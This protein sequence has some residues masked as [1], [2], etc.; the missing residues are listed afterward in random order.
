MGPSGSASIE[1]MPAQTVD[2]RLASD[3]HHQARGQPD[4]NDTP[5]KSR[6][7]TGISWFIAMFAII[8]STFLY[9]LDNTVLANVRPSIIE[10]FGHIDLLTWVS[11]A[12]PLG[13]VGSNPL[14]GKLNSYFNTKV[15]YL[16]TLFIFEVGSAVIGSAQS[17][18]GVI[19]GRAIAGFGG[20]GIYVCTINIVSSLTT[21][22]ERNQYLNYVGIAWALGTVLGPIIGG[23][24]ADS[25]ATWRWAFYINIVI[26]AVTTPACVF[27]I[28]PL[29]PSIAKSSTWWQRL[30]RIDYVGEVLWLGGIVTVVTILASGG[31]L[32]AWDS[33]QLIGLYVAAGVAWILF[34][35]QQRFRLFTTDRIFPLD[36]AGTWHMAL[37]F[38]WSSIAIANN[39]VTI[40]SLPLLYQ[41]SFNDSPLQAALWTLPF[42]AA[43]IVIG[44]PLGPLFPKYSIYKV[45]FLAASVLMIVGAGLMSTI[46][47]NTSRAAI[48]GY[49]VI[50]GAG[51]GPIIQLPFTVGQAKVHPSKAGSVTAFFTCAQMVGLV[52]SLGI[53]TAVFLNRATDEIGAILTDYPRSIIQAAISGIGSSAF[54]NLNS[55]TRG[56]ITA[57]VARSLGRVFYLNLA[58]AALGF[59][60]AVLMKWEKLELQQNER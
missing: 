60:T 54:D 49:T 55:D 53:A 17:I 20:S 10:T 44:G 48:T 51:C 24:F 52:L 28:P 39:T 18:I 45:W 7:L 59:V 16:V 32:Y 56:Q 25:E 5:N 34:L 21:P 38:C 26:A 30:K 3:E 6:K 31:A 35:V 4:I 2:S 47:F 37:L 13:E 22:A 1:M 27:L 43:L 42:I 40:Y 12:Y 50:Q 23:A 15:L 9:A 11:V 58:G 36:L 19:V 33:P 46:D 14:W 8:S 41:F 57:I 29:V